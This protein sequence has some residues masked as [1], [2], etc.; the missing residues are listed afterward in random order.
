MLSWPRAAPYVPLRYTASVARARLATT[1]TPRRA[2]KLMGPQM[3]PK[4]G[5]QVKVE[6]TWSASV[7]GAKPSCGRVKCLKEAL[8]GV[9]GV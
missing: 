1:S 3:G 9:C 5:Q 8:W 6:L 4:Q 7:L 2:K